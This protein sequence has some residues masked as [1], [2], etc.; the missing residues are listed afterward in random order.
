MIASLDTGPCI[1]PPGT[2]GPGAKAC[3]GNVWMIAIDASTST[4][5]LV[6]RLYVCVRTHAYMYCMYVRIN[7]RFVFK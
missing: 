3:V 6:V 4:F 1:N 5:I 7:I 2:S